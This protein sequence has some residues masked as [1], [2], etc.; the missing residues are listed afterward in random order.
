MAL[1]ED[2]DG[3]IWTATFGGGLSRR[4][5]ATGAFKRYR[6]D[7]NDAGSIAGDRVFS[8]AEDRAGRIWAGTTDGLCR[9]DRANGAFRKVELPLTDMTMRS[10]AESSS[11]TLWLANFTGALV[12][13]EVATG[14]IRVH[15]NRPDQEDG[16]GDNR[17]QCLLLDRSG[18]LWVGTWGGGLN[19]LRSGTGLFSSVRKGESGS[20]GLS[21]PDVTAVHE[22]REGRLWVGTFGG[23]LNRREPGSERW[24]WYNAE[25]P[26]IGNAT[27]VLSIREAANGSL[28][29][30]MADGLLHFDP[31]RGGS[32]VFRH[33]PGDPRGL[34]PGY[35][36]AI[37]EDRAGRLWV[38]TGGGGLHRLSDDGR[39]FDRYRN[40]PGD[41]GSL[42]DDY[43]TAIL[44]DRAGALWV[45]TRSGGLNAFDRG[46][47]KFMRY[48]PDTRDPGSLSHHYVCSLCEAPDGTLWVATG[49]GGLDRVER[50]GSRVR[51]ARFTARDGL[52][53]DNVVSVAPDDDGSLWLGTRRGL[54]RFDPVRRVFASY[55]VA[56]GLPSGEFNSGA[57]TEGARSL[58][59]GTTKGVVVIPR[60]TPFR[61]PR[62][63]PTLVTS[64][65]TLTGPFTGDR[66]PWLLEQVRIP[67]GRALLVDF[68][69]L[70]FRES[71]RHRHAYRFEGEEE[72]WIDLGTRHELT[73]SD[74]APGTHT[75]LVKGRNAEGAWSD[76]A[77]PLRIEVVPPFWMTAWFRVLLFLS[78][79]SALIAWHQVRTRGLERR[80]RELLLLQEQREQA[81]DAAQAKERELQEA[82]DR[83]R[84]L[85]RRL[86]AAKEDERRHIARE[87]HDEMGQVLTAAKINLQMLKRLPDEEKRGQRVADTVDLV[88][89]MIRHVRALSLDLRPPLLDE[90]GLVPALGAYLE[91]QAQRS[92]VA[93][94]LVADGVPAGIPPEVQ[95][96]VFRV[97]QEAV[98]N[99]LRHALA[100]RAAIEI[101]HEPSW[102]KVDI[103]DDGSG[104]DYAD[105]MQRAAAGGHLGLLG[106]VE[107]LRGLGGDV[108]I[109]TSPGHGTAIRVRVPL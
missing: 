81:L 6:H 29:L 46:A 104:F 79:A 10:I 64:I 26:P 23:G 62:P 69:V 35:V 92:G 88:D 40:I 22:D 68:A 93:F 60:G 25:P 47:G 39:S 61:S 85:T 20:V 102:L 91:A 14:A 82:Y 37:H 56:D 57:V 67:Y 66:P 72:G 27:N 24:R 55:G 17:I 103:R 30:A 86:E 42:S 70:D 96:V 105:A 87:L 89:R 58:Y 71:S 4:D 36:T 51:F 63:S 8:I 53:D 75:L 97:I 101:R 74:L 45:G 11:G 31:R 84:A 100:R 32:E 28:W 98:T 21:N 77:P 13:I 94:D 108:E 54:A 78:V 5:P 107:R 52:V 16:L 99:V 106:I 2:R 90:L 95:I 34:G 43:V 1:L 50:D 33:D 44:E 48:L 65:R 7:P 80:N 19:R 109:D 15:Q 49:G 38:G 73:F 83:L 59:F 76:A 18:A 9:M 41:P 3:A 12:E